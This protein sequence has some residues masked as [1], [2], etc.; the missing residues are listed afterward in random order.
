MRVEVENLPQGITAEARQ[1][2]FQR[3]GHCK[4]ELSVKFI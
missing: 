2:E 1:K 4:V 3:V